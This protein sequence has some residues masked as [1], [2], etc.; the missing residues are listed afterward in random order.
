MTYR[1]DYGYNKISD[2]CLMNEGPTE[3]DFAEQNSE[4]DNDKI[5]SWN[6]YN[7]GVMLRIMTLRVP[8]VRR[9]L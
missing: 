5:M 8:L 3:S 9:A 7:V 6:D 2:M 1:T 4:G